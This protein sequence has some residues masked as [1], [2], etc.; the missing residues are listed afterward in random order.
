VDTP[1]KSHPHSFKVVLPKR[2]L[3]L[4]AGSDEEMIGWIEALRTVHG[5]M[6]RW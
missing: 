5:Q 2:S 3:I 1:S 4:S 6:K